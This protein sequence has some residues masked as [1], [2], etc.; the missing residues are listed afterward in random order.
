[1][2]AP[3]QPPLADSYPTKVA[4]VL[5][6][7][8]PYIVVTTAATL[9]QQPVMKDLH[10][11]RTALEMASGLANAG[12]AFGAVLAALMAKKVSLRSALL[13]YEALFVA[14]SVLVAVAPDLTAF[15]IGR[16][17]QGAATGLM[18]VAALPPL[19]TG[20][21]TA[22]LPVTAAVVDIGLFGATTVGPL[23]GGEIGAH[24]SWRLLFWILAGFGVVALVVEAA[25][26]AH[27]E[28]FQPDAPLD[29]TGIG[30]ALAATT[31]PF[32]GA[33]MLARE[34][35]V[36]WY[37]LPFLAVG[38][39]ALVVL[40]A[41]EYRREGAVTPVR[42]LSH[43]L[44]VTGIFI[45]MF[46]GAAAV[47]L[48]ELAEEL[49]MKG[50]H[51]GPLLSGELFWPQVVG[52]ALAAGAFGLLFR[53]RH[54]TTL[55]VVGTLVLVAGSL[56]LALASHRTGHATILLVAAAVGFGAGATVSPGLFLAALSIPSKQIG[57]AFALVELLRSEAAFLLGPILLHVSL[58]QGPKRA[59][60]D[61]GVSVGGWTVFA[62]LVGGLVVSLALWR[63]AGARSHAPDLERWLDDGEEA[64]DSPPVLAQ[65][66]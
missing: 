10:T 22:K 49:V 66:R 28:P 39:G 52:V 57:P 16:V 15:T 47:S 17:A 51:T 12:Y 20:F 40:I 24:G 62:V 43:T 27:T 1:M 63:S 2:P 45:A 14:G 13:G 19:V 6:A 64:L 65:V 31:L 36:S 5:L 26:V 18:L 55:I 54:I 48:L 30:L 44:P 23:I 9:F 7:L 4:V 8:C 37:V 35:F 32:I 56:G 61:H 59:A 58:A 29:L 3:H 41:V 33:S 53:S 25:S 21:G 46:T 34:P 42:Q 11:S 60:L 50:M 38:L